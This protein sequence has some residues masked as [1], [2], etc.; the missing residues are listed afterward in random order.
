MV[1]QSESSLIEFANLTTY[2]SMERERETHTYI[3]TQTYKQTLAHN[4]QHLRNRIRLQKTKLLVA[5]SA[6]PGI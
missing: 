5:F 3:H 4:R 1:E 6:G 2:I